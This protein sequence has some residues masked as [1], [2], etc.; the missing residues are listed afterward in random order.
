[1]LLQGGILWTNYHDG[2]RTVIYKG[3]KAGKYFISG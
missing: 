2:S 3:K 1:M